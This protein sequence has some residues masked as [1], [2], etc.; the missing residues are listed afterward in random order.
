MDETACNYDS[1]A[2]TYMMVQ[3]TYAAEG[4]DCAGNCLSGDIS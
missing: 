2:V 4:F 1:E 3:C